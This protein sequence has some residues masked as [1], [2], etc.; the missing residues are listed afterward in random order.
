M[1]T[2]QS[3]MDHGM[4]PS[5]VG[6]SLQIAISQ[7]FFFNYWLVEL[8][9]DGQKWHCSPTSCYHFEPDDFRTKPEADDACSALGGHLVAMETAEEQQA[10]GDMINDHGKC[11]S[12]AE[13]SAIIRL[14]IFSCSLISRSLIP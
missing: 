10:I 1:M 12:E 9:L 4:I 11:I 2:S 13:I 14:I 3:V 7:I 5:F 8:V 6:I